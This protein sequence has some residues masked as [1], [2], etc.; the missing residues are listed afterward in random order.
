MGGVS[1]PQ[2]VLPL[3][4]EELSYYLAKIFLLEELCCIFGSLWRTVTSALLLFCMQIFVVAQ[5]SVAFQSLKSGKNLK[6][7]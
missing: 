3:C 1:S 4:A 7:I 2:Q 5:S 6:E